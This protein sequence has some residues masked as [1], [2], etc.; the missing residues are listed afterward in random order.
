[1]RSRWARG[2]PDNEGPQPLESLPEAW[3]QGAEEFVPGA[4]IESVDFGTRNG[5]V[6]MVSA[7]ENAIPVVWLVDEPAL[8][9][10]RSKLLERILV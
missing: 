2:P 7:G 1:M 8:G 4:S 5:T 10:E 3:L 9:G 6:F